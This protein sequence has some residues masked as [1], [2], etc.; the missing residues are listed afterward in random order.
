MLKSMLGAIPGVII[1][2]VKFIFQMGKKKSE[3]SPSRQEYESLR[4]MAAEAL[5]MNARYYCNPVDIAQYGNRLPKAYK[6]GSE[7]LR[8]LGARFRGFAETLPDEVRDLPL[9][10]AQIAEVG[11]EFIG[12]SNSF[13]TPYLCP[14][15]RCSVQ[16]AR[17]MEA[18]IRSLLDISE[19]E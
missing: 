3:K 10:K 9:S 13:N 18:T 15:D 14:E 5:T 16:A 4:R 6:K 7:A 17:E 8:E 2:L 12:L 1:D 19:I 11:S